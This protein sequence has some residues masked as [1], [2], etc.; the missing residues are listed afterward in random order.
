M[1]HLTGDAYIQYMRRD[2]PL[3]SIYIYRHTVHRSTDISL[4]TIQYIHIYRHTV[5]RSTD[6][7]LYS[8]YTVSTD[9]PLYNIHTVRTCTRRKKGKKPQLNPKN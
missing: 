7:P 8:I 3:Y 6:I 9:I 2:I 5:H 4:Y 1:I